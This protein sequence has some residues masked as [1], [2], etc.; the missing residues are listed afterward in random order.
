MNRRPIQVLVVVTAVALAVAA[1]G[2]AVAGAHSRVRARAADATS[3]P[4]AALSDLVCHHALNPSNRSVSATAVMR[5][6][7][8]TAKLAVKFRLVR[9]TAGSAPSDV[10]GPGLGTWLT[11]Q[12]GKRPGDVWRVIH[13]VSDL[14]APAGYRF[15]VSFRWISSSGQILARATRFSRI[16]H[17]PELRPDLEVLS[18]TVA[19]DPAN[20]QDDYYRALI[21]DAGAT[22]AGPFQ[23]Q[24][25]DQGTVANHRVAHIYPH[26]T[27]A[28]RLAGPVCSSSDPPTVTVDPAHRIDVYSRSQASLSANCPAPAS[29]SGTTAT[30]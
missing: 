6:V 13:T 21:K 5:P 18:I 26:Q 27:L 2:G 25:S 12:F 14:S 9:R 10:T 3:P 7:P 29:A 17:Q 15:A 8:G 20:A 22:G 28:V 4:R 1:M 11:K 16:C 30:G 23:V 24:L 19:G